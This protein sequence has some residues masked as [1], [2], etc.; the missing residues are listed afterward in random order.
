MAAM[1]ANPP[2][3]PR[4]PPDQGGWKRAWAADGSRPC[5]KCRQA[6]RSGWY[7]WKVGC[8]HPDCVSHLQIYL[9][10]IV[11]VNVYNAI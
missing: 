10:M 8:T 2:D 3:P 9:L 5:R 11:I 7:Y 4:D 1:G 6:G